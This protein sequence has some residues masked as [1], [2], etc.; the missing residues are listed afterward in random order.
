MKEKLSHGGDLEW[1]VWNRGEKIF[2]LPAK[3][4]AEREGEQED[5][6]K[7]KPEDYIAA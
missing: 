6:P 1:A 4:K 3:T 2:S 5:G 7:L